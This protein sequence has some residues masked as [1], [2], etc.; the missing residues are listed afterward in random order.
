VQSRA[1]LQGGSG[2]RSQRTQQCR[3]TTSYTAEQTPYPTETHRVVD[4]DPNVTLRPWM[5]V[6]AYLISDGRFFLQ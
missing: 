2:G 6:V 4:G 5:A 3:A 1:A